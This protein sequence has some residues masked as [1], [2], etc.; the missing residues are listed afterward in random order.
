MWEKNELNLLFY[1]EVKFR[2]YVTV[3]M[4]LKNYSDYW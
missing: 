3:E 4:S 2:K 1:G